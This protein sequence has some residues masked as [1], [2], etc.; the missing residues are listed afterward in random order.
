M[1][2]PTQNRVVEFR[3]T[4]GGALERVVKLHGGRQDLHRCSRE[5]FEA[6]AGYLDDHSR[7]DVKLMSLADALDAP[8][9]QVNMAL[10]LLI[11]RGML[12]ARA[13]GRL[14]R[15]TPGY[16]SAFYEHAMTEFWALIEGHPPEFCKP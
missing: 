8:K 4:P 9:T 7:D 2:Q 14:S 13:D 5:V 11:E 6:V 12:K 15:V 1:R 10:E 16:A 3:G